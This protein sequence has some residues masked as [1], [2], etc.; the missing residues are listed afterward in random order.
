MDFPQVDQI[1]VALAVVAFVMVALWLIWFAS[2]A[3]FM[4]CPETGAVGL[5]DVDPVQTANGETVRLGVRQCD[6]WPDRQGCARGCLA[7][8][9]GYSE[10]APWY[11]VGLE[12][13]RRFERANPLDPMP[14]A[15]GKATDTAHE[16][17]HTS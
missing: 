1:V 15:Q 10:T 17:R 7:R 4:R 8:Y 2:S 12:A 16:D 14:T 9:S 11:R 6:L 5:V 3:R 13:L